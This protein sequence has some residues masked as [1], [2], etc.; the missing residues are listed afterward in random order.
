METTLRPRT[1][2]ARRAPVK[3]RTAP[4]PKLA[5]KDT[6]PLA[7]SPR[8]RTRTAPAQSR[9]ETTVST[10]QEPF[11]PYIL[12]TDRTARGWLRWAGQAVALSIVATLIWDRGTSIRPEIKGQVKPLAAPAQWVSAAILGLGSLATAVALGLPW[13]ALPFAAGFAVITRRALAAEGVGLTV[14]AATDRL[15]RKVLLAGV[16][17]GV[18]WVSILLAAWA[19]TVTS[20]LTSNP[21]TQ[22]A[23]GATAAAN[24]QDQAAGITSTI[25]SVGGIASSVLVCFSI[26][27]WAQSTHAAAMDAADESRMAAMK[28]P[29]VEE[30]VNV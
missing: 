29:L 17:F 5:P 26:L 4:I 14:E 25:A 24:L 2:T 13:G 19:G 3:P 27:W 9:Q 22:I 16:G 28:A 18:W 12:P 23:M 7:S 20:T 1:R 21:M 15:I 6:V 30:T 10:V 11:N 8:P